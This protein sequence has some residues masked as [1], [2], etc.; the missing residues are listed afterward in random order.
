MQNQAN[1][2]QKSKKTPE[3]KISLIILCTNLHKPNVHNFHLEVALGI[4]TDKVQFSR[5][6]IGSVCYWYWS[7]ALHHPKALPQTD[8]WDCCWRMLALAVGTNE[9]DFGHFFY[10]YKYGKRQTF[11][12]LFFITT[13]ITITWA[14]LEII[15][16]EMNW[17]LTDLWS[18]ISLIS[19]TGSLKKTGRGPPPWLA[20]TVNWRHISYL[21]LCGRQDVLP[22]G[23]WK[24]E[25]VGHHLAPSGHTALVVQ[26]ELLL[27]PAVRHYN[28]LCSGA[29]YIIWNLF[30]FSTCESYNLS[31]P[32]MLYMS[33][34]KV[35]DW[36]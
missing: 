33:L 25:H 15:K 4:N 13:G 21:T 32:V 24:T 35:L 14:W 29:G 2:C 7:L 28:P 19:E 6:E 22:V 34:M 18:S 11:G 3:K 17:I 10:G 27:R 16:L 20:S 1:S 26:V 23:V 36:L 30:Y 8:V 12:N 5:E 9:L 31:H